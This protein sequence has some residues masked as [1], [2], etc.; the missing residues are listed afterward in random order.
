[1]PNM[2]EQN[3]AILVRFDQDDDTVS[4]NPLDRPN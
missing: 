1:M 4:R 2:Y 3:H